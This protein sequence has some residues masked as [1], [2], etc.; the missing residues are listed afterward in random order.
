MAR[1]PLPWYWPERKGWYT[2]LNGKRQP[3]GPHPSDLPPPQ[4][5]KGKWVAPAAITQAFHALLAEPGGATKT[6]T[7][8]RPQNVP[9]PDG[10]SV[11]EVL[12]RYLDWCQKHR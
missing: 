10:L 8:P 1:T 7:N 2:I 3:L 11:A 9:T 4:K 6:A 5:R 12:D